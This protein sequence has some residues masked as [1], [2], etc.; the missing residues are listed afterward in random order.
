MTLEALREEVG[1]NTFFKIMR[2]WARAHAYGNAGTRQFMDLAESDSGMDLG[3][4]FHEW[5]FKR[6]KPRNWGS[7]ALRQ[8]H[9]AARGAGAPAS[10]APAGLGAIGQLR[11]SP[12]ATGPIP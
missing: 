12:A 4:F 3:H 2:D 7:S 9:V 11:L 5:L 10:A 6:G 1:A 8:D